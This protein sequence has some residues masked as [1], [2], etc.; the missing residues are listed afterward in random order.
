[1]S[2]FQVCDPVEFTGQLLSSVIEEGVH[3][4]A[5]GTYPVQY[6]D[7]QF[8]SYAPGAQAQQDAFA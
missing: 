8:V 5:G 6:I 7:C 2:F 4:D 3:V 1:M